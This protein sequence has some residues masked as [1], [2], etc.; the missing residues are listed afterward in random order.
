MTLFQNDTL[1]LR[2]SLLRSAMR[3]PAGRKGISRLSTT[4]RTSCGQ[5]AGHVARDREE[6]HPRD[7][8]PPHAHTA[9]RGKAPQEGAS[10]GAREGE[11]CARRGDA[12]ILASSED[13]TN[14]VSELTKLSQTPSNRTLEDANSI[15]E[16]AVSIYKNLFPH[17]FFDF[18]GARIPLFRMDRDNMKRA[19]INLITNSIKAI[20][21]EPGTIEVT[22][23][24]DRSR[25]MIRI[26][27]A[28][29][30][31]GVEDED[32][33]RISTPISPMTPMARASA[34]PSSIP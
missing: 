28:D 32:K 34:W 2:A 8:K 25:G 13:I 16:E 19:F 4:S 1:Y 21:E 20:A 5:K 33:E 24:Y 30:G 23:R 7:K 17:I 14:M 26:E 12:I 18:H 22:S 10:Q 3:R 31:P 11:G 15:I 9:V 27:V 6:A 29:T